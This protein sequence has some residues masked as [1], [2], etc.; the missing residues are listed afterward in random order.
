MES[1]GA[2]WPA[3]DSRRKCRSFSLSKPSSPSSLTFVPLPLLRPRKAKGCSL[4]RSALPCRTA[5]HSSTP[6]LEHWSLPAPPLLFSSAVDR[7]LSNSL[8]TPPSPLSLSLAVECSMQI[9]CR[10]APA[11]STQRP[12]GNT[13]TLVTPSAAPCCSSHLARPNPVPNQAFDSFH[14]PSFTRISVTGVTHIL[15]TRTHSTA[16]SSSTCDTVEATTLTF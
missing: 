1:C 2:D 13:T 16:D 10:A 3:A 12:A 6:T 9:V 15:A 5:E 4:V 14:R 7:A 11:P 8:L